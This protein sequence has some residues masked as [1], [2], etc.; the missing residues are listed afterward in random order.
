MSTRVPRHYELIIAGEKLTWTCYNSMA[1]VMKYPTLDAPADC[2]KET[3]CEGT[4]RKCWAWIYRLIGAKRTTFEFRQIPDTQSA[5]TPPAELLPEPPV[6]RERRIDLATGTITPDVTDF[7]PPTTGVYTVVIRTPGIPN[8]ETRETLKGHGMRWN[9]NDGRG[10]R[11]YPSP[12]WLR[13]HVPAAEL[14]HYRKLATD[15]KLDFDYLDKTPV[16][17]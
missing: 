13:Y 17:P 9:P 12:A 3:V 16:R 10:D 8:K 7:N 14:V 5:G 15:L 11:N 6:H 1:A 2:D 4:E